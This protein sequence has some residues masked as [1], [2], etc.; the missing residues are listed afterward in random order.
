MPKKPTLP[1][2]PKFLAAL[3]LQHLSNL[4]HELHLAHGALDSLLDSLSN[5]NESPNATKS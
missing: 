3:L 2:D 5:Q 4:N 1:P